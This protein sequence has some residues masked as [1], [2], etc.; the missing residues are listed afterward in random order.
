MELI[1]HPKLILT[2]D[3]S[4]RVIKDGYIGIED[5]KI[6]YVGEKKPE[7]DGE[8]LEFKNGL[9]IPGLIDSH[10]HVAMTL[11]RGLKDDVDLITWLNKYIFP[12]EAKL[13]AEH[14]YYGSLL[15][16]AELVSSGVTTI[17]DMYYFM[18]KIADATIEIGS[19]ALLSRG[20]LDLVS[21]DR[22][23]ESEI[24]LAHEFLSYIE[25]LWDKDPKLKDQIMFA[26]GPHAPYTCS[27]E[28]L[29]LVKEESKKRGFKIHMHISETKW[30]RE[31]IKKRTGLTPVR[32]LESINFLDDSVIAI[33]VVWVDEEEIG[34][35]SK[36]NV[37]VVHNPISNLKLAS[38]FAPIP[39]ML[40]QNVNVAIGTDGPASNNRLDLFREMHVAAIMHKGYKLDPSIVPAKDVIKMATI[41]G[42]KALGLGDKIGSIEEGKYA[43]LVVIDIDKVLQ[44]HPIHDIYSML[45]YALDPSAVKHVMVNGE[46]IYWDKQFKNIDIE[47]VK[48]KVEAIRKEIIEEK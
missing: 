25:N 8:V 13:T 29:K 5:R 12:A 1:L 4:E 9:V 35:L 39:T 6:V 11:L 41:N 3:K 42:A 24:K 18:E 37:S 32:Y 31:E 28:L 40:E 17:N 22:T 34:I 45:V 20:I 46:W 43:D 7:G 2:M 15:G 16:I 30:E 14:V 36:R 19:R 26:Y 21:E 47:K 33:H 48:D 44:A 10:T 27:K 23:P 38:G